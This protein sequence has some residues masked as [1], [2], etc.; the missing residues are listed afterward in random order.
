MY[1]YLE[2]YIENAEFYHISIAIM[3][4]I[5][6]T[7]KWLPDAHYFWS[8]WRHQVEKFSALLAIC[9]GNS[10]VPGEFPTQKPVTQ[11]FDVFF[12]LR[13][14]KRLSKQSWGWW[15]ETLSRPI[16]CHCNVVNGT[17]YSISHEHFGHA[18]RNWHPIIQLNPL[19]SSA[20]LDLVMNCPQ[21]RLDAF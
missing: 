3:H 18:T 12:D 8:W 19:Y 21:D 17:E 2:C 6:V 5:G 4:D 7:A 1:M 10:P 14:N 20:I 11:S 9:A 13:L 15:F 16:W